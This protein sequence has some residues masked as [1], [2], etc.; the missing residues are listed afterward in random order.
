MTISSTPLTDTKRGT[1]HEHL[2][3]MVRP[4]GTVVNAF[5]ARWDG[6][7]QAGQMGPVRATEIGRHTGARI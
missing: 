5:R 6:W 1:T 7:A 4:M 2:Y 3:R